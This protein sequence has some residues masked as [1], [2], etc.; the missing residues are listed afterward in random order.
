ME[1]ADEVI[2]R[3]RSLEAEPDLLGLLGLLSPP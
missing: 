1:A 3:C 2:A